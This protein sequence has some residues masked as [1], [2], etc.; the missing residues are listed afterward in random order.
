MFWGRDTEGSACWLWLSAAAWHLRQKQTTRASMQSPVSLS[1]NA[2]RSRPLSTAVWSSLY[3]R[4]FAFAAW[5][6][7]LNVH[8][9]LTDKYGKSHASAC[10]RLTRD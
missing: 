5:Y 10:V 4:L 9:A 7:Q 3:L 8:A 1:E 6:S 2:A